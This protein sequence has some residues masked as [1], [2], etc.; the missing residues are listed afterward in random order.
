MVV[1]MGLCHSQPRPSFYLFP[2]DLFHI[3][4]HTFSLLRTEP[5]QGAHK[6]RSSSAR[7]MQT[8]MEV[9]SHSSWAMMEE[10]RNNPVASRQEPPG[11]CRRSSNLTLTL[12]GKWDQ[13]YKGSLLGP[14]NR[15]ICKAYPTDSTQQNIEF[16]TLGSLSCQPMFLHMH[17]SVNFY[18]SHLFCSLVLYWI[19]TEIIMNMSK[20]NEAG[21]K[22][23]PKTH[24]HC[25]TA[26]QCLTSLRYK[27]S[28]V[29]PV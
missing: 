15:I 1:G 6:I 12:R 7:E 24:K 23:I 4:S 16:S 13:A 3:Q 18:I 27:C 10:I 2:V 22:S 17:P 21:R 5:N 29:L 25:I 8:L 26:C 11:T 14:V 28:L 9:L 19:G 20:S